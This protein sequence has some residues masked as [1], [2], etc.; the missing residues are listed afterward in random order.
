MSESASRIVARFVAAAVLAASCACGAPPATDGEPA[1]ASTPTPPATRV[2][3][4]PRE[5]PDVVARVDGEEIHKWE[6]EAAL[7]EITFGNM[8]PV[9]QSER[10]ELV[11]LLLDRIIGH[12][13]AADLARKRQVAVSDAELEQDLRAMRGRYPTDRAFEDTL[14]SFGV[15]REQ[16]RHQ[17]RL[18]LDVAKLVEAAVAPAVKVSDS[19][20][21]AYYRENQ[22]RFQVPETVTASHILIRATPDAPASVRAEARRRA[23]GLLDE[24]RGGADFAKLAQAHSEDTGTAA[25]GGLLGAF[26]RGRMDPA[27]EAAAF[28][29]RPGEISDLVETSFGF[30]IIRVDQHQAGRLPPLDEVRTDVREL[31]IERGRQ[32]GLTKLIEEARKGAKIEILI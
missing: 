2:A 8:H 6:V 22:Q 3:P 25:S 1:Q 31:L 13:L 14:D 30:H 16:L 15:T 20:I 4:V 11:R 7:R 24:I 28:S 23:A 26:P 12:H 32:E 29:T 9:P 17:R 18:S 21:E 10:D 19:D 5:L 27:F